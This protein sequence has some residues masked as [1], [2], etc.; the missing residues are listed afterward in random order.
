[1]QIEHIRGRLSGEGQTKDR[2]AEVIT[3]MSA[4][5]SKE[6]ATENIKLLVRCEL[7]VFKGIVINMVYAQQVAQAKAAEA[8]FGSSADILAASMRYAAAERLDWITESEVTIRDA[9]SCKNYLAYFHA[10][11]NMIRVKYDYEVYTDMST[12]ERPVPFTPERIEHLNNMI[13]II[14]DAETYF[15]R[16]ADVMNR[17]VALALLFE[18]LHYSGDVQ[19]ADQTLQTLSDL[20]EQ[21]EIAEF[22]E[23]LVI[24]RTAGPTHQRFRAFVDAQINEIENIDAEYYDMLNQMQELDKSD[25]EAMPLMEPCSMVELYPIGFFTFPESARQHVYEI[26]NVDSYARSIFDKRFDEHAVPIANISNS[27]IQTE[28][29][30][31]RMEFGNDLHTWDNIFR[32]RKAFHD[33]GY[34][35][36][37][38]ESTANS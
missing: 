8:Y 20:V 31:E 5:L 4:I 2:L 6:D 17:C 14:Q 28:G 25:L 15:T 36:I 33:N 27:T 22:R 7:I 11:L 19:H 1:V 30:G 37:I 12:F 38:P 9:W 23:K 32:I 13:R 21:Y 34:R 26:L 10:H 18:V 3:A 24:L 29:Y 16:V 35:R